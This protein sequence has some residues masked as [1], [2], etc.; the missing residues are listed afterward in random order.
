MILTPRSRALRYGS[1]PTNAGRNEWWMLITGTPSRSRKS[2]REDLHVAGEHDQI[3][4]CRRAARAC[5]PRPS[6]SV[7]RDRH[8]VER[9]AEAAHVG[10]E[11]GWLEID[12]RRRRRRARRGATARAGRAGSGRR[13][14]PASRCASARSRTRAA[15]PSRT[16][17]RPR[18][19]VALELARARRPSSRNS[20]RMKNRPPSGSVEYWSAREDV[21][22]GLGE[23]AR[24]R[25]DDPRPVRARD[26]QPREFSRSSIPSRACGSGRGSR[27]P[28][29][30]ARLP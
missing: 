26:Q 12:E 28:A 19:E 3:G 4:R 16:A 29:P 30:R 7:S 17:R 5:A 18:R 8:V 10:V 14:R 9:H 24:D 13:A 6:A 23:E 1:A 21:R 27:A 11:I 2:R 20:I 15:S 25:G 22:A